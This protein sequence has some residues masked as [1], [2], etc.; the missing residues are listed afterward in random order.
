MD[1]QEASDGGG[2]MTTPTYAPSM[3]DQAQRD[4]SDGADPLLADLTGPQRDAV[5]CTEGPLLVLAAAGS[6]KTRVIT[7]RIAHLVRTGVPPW[8]ILAVTFTNKAAGEMR[9]RALDAVGS[10]ESAARGLTVTTFHALCARL[11]RRYAEVSGI[12]GLKPDFAIYD[13]ADQLDLMKRT[14]AAL[15]VSKENF[16]PRSVLETI[17]RAKN[18]SQDPNLFAGAARDFYGKT[19]ARVYRA[20]QAALTSA[21][22]VDFDDLLMHVSAM[23]KQKV[24]IRAEC[25]S[26][27]RYL[28][29]DEYQD[30]NRVQFEIASLLA[31]AGDGPNICVVGD[32]DQSIYAWRGADISNILEFES[33]YPTAKVIALGENFRSTAPIL[34]AAD[35]LIK[36]NAMRKH[37]PL[38][39]RREGG[40][41][42]EI[43]LCRDEHHEAMIVRDW[44]RELHDAP[45]GP[46]W[47]DLAVFYR[48]NALSRVM[49]DILRRAGIPYLVARGTAFYQREEV[50]NALAYLRVLANPADDVSVRRIINTPA[51][52]ISDATVAHLE[53]WSTSLNTPL[54]QTMREPAAIDKLNARAKTAVAG[55]VAKIDAWSG[56][57]TF[58]GDQVATTLTELVRQVI[59]ESGLESMYRQQAARTPTEA[60]ESRV[61]NLHEIISAAA[62]F[63]LEYDPDSD[64]AFGPPATNANEPSPPSLHALL[65][66]YLESVALVADAD[67][68][69]PD[70]GAV[71]LMTL[72]AAK[73][74]EFAGVAMIALEE[75]VLPGHRALD[76]E[77]AME[78]ERRLT[79]VGIT[80]AMRRLLITSAARRTQRGISERTM[81]SRFLSEIDLAVVNW[82]DRSGQ[83]EWSDFGDGGV[84]H[85]GEDSADAGEGEFKP[86]LRVIHPQFGTGEILSVEGGVKPRVTIRFRGIGVKTIVLGYVP[87]KVLP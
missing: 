11:L 35:S 2:D 78:E 37:K 74:L 87:I 36:H 25:Q 86:G 68:V 22:A 33:R 42:V 3:R 81:A 73:G 64:P 56:K 31:G 44:L 71:T 43:T 12:A 46:A 70:Q 34:K 24:E 29:I 15:D 85:Y 69:D 1:E 77:D 52:G 50:K 60:E 51:R 5:L 80:R 49:E 18:A 48:N 16:P 76:H 75:G 67:T 13:S 7:R 59:T 58:F 39:T 28:L 19:V 62:D 55:F 14:L 8:S 10:D 54:L 82:Q 83:S 38:F 30:T 20:Y 27:W 61:A 26:R 84:E 32:P 72:H 40:E 6:G 57:G 4:L 21:N 9:Q 79:F 63:E 17:S 41:P 66:A 47:R 65:R 23:L 53:S 45:D